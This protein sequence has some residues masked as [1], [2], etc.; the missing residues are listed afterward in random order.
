MPMTSR[1]IES[2]HYRA[3][4]DGLRGLAILA[5][6]GYH[7]G[8]PSF[9]GGFVGV[10]VFFVISG[11][12]ITQLLKN[13]IKKTGTLSF[14]NFYARRVRRLLPAMW[15]VVIATLL[16]WI[17]F[18]SGL[19][20]TRKFAASTRWSLLGLANIFFKK[21]TGG[22]FDG[23]TA[24]MPFLHFW[25]LAVEEQFYGIW[26]LLFFFLRKRSRGLFVILI[27]ITL[28]SFF[29]SQI[30]I[31]KG[32]Q[33]SAFYLMP[34]RAWELAVGSLLVFFPRVK[35]KF[36]FLTSLLGFSLIGMAIFC[37][38]AQTPFPGFWALPPV[39]GTAF[40]IGSESG[41]F[42]KVLSHSILNRIG[43]LSY[44]WYLWHWPLLALA[45][46]WNLSVEPPL[47][48]RLLILGLSLILAELSLR[49]IETPIRHGRFWSK[50]K[51]WSIIGVAALVCA[52]LIGGTLTLSLLE[53]RMLSARYGSVL[54]QKIREK[55]ELALNCFSKMD[56]GTPRCNFSFSDKSN[57]P[58][59]AIWGDSHSCSYFPMV[60]YYARK[61]SLKATL[62]CQ[63]DTPPLLD[64]SADF[65]N[66]VIEDI[67]R[68]QS[69][70]T[71]VSV[72]LVARWMAYSRNQSLSQEKLRNTLN[73]LRR[74][75]VSKILIILPYPEFKLFTLRCLRRDPEHCF[76]PRSEVEDHR[77]AGVT[78][79]R[80]VAASFPHVRLLDPLPSICS[81]SICPQILDSQR[82][83]VPVVPVVIDDNHPSLAAVYRIGEKNKEDLDWLL[84]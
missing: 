57:A 29:G 27:G 18:L 37:Y 13:E 3:D 41:P 36:R 81:D 65:G 52:C 56:I 50:Q 35:V 83:G 51:S 2:S 12:L 69:T 10:D 66:A 14:R 26:P 67:K 48:V 20:D 62:Y 11:F 55:S 74:I 80:D 25:S 30:W 19:G 34:F 24:E 32:L 72:I 71:A 64:A 1:K 7:A 43:I 54:I 28:I 33:S 45:R 61:N 40:L 42:F 15:I 38:T 76:L 21:N 75:G 6:I 59:L 4:I 47:Y 8:L 82:S 78:L 31:Q 73:E 84:E 68:L 46:I 22:Y 79:I 53:D 49:W 70:N 5:V 39:L 63:G 23:P 16:L 77:A 60:E 58:T 17:L 9:K 44:G